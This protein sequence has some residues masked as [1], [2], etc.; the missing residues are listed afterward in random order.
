M[1][2]FVVRCMLVALAVGAMGGLA[3]PRLGFAA[4]EARGVGFVPEGS[5][6]ANVE[7]LTLVDI[8]ELPTLERSLGVKVVQFRHEHVGPYT[9]LTAGAVVARGQE[10][11]AAIDDHLTA[12]AQWFAGRIESLERI[13]GQL[14][15]E[16]H[17][18]ALRTIEDVRA[19]RDDF[20]KNG[21]RI[22]SLIVYGSPRAIGELASKANVKSVGVR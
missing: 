11:Q 9:T 21:A 13:A 5:R 22:G 1:I 19:A 6:A 8:R 20:T 10:L 18:A 3:S 15:G 17:A 4:P 14:N 7:L 12:Q 16:Q 2:L